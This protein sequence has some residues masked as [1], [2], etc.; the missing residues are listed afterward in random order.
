MKLHV[1]LELLDD[2]WFKEEEQRLT[3]EDTRA[4]WVTQS[5]RDVLVLQRIADLPLGIR[6]REVARLSK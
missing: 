6:V 4:G 1:V 5:E 2:R 3:F